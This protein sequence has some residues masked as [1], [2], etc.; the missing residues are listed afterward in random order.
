MAAFR[1]LNQA[2]QYFLP[3]GRVND[4][5][6]LTFYETDLTT[7]KDT[8]SDEALTTLN[9]NPVQFDAAGRTLTDVWGDGEYGIEMR[10]ALG[11]VIWTRNNVQAGGDASQTIPALESGRFLRNDGTTMFW[12][13]ILQ[14]PDPTDLANYQLESD[15]TGIPVWVQKAEPEPPA[16]SDIDNTSTYI[17]LNTYLRQ[18]GTGTAPSAASAKTSS[19]NITFPKAFSGTPYHASV[20]ITESGGS[21]PSGAI[22]TLA[23]TGLTSTGMTV[24]VNMPDD[25]SNSSWKLASATPFS[26][27]VEGPT[28]LPS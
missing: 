18:W 22:C 14:V 4:G 23:V 20:T 27:S 28:V 17:R 2:P 6:S 1:I 13:D 9:D 15:G 25:D 3:D 21:T 11:T 7:L 5:G 10:D 19:V 24:T 16:E 12:D 8:W 26:Y